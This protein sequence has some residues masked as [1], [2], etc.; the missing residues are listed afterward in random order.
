[1]EFIFSLYLLLIILQRAFSLECD[2]SKNEK[3]IDCHPEADPNENNCLKRGCCWRPLNENELNYNIDVPYCHFPSDY[4]Q[5]RVVSGGF[6]Q[7]GF[8]CSILKDNFTFT[9]NE[10]LKLNVNITFV[11]KK[12]LRVKIFDPLVE[13]Y[14]V[15]VFLK[16]KNM[17][18]FNQVQD[19][20]YQ[21]YIK[22]NPFS[23]KIFRKSTGKL[24]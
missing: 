9:S 20:D 23:L 12:T 17:Q 16:N 6:V 22:E 11:N 19:N 21:I 1:M 8:I 24:M 18:N 5:Y 4:P 3:R 2:I 14:E 15:P 13:R 7:N 10:I